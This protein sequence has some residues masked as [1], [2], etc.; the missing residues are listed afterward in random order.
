MVN[1]THILVCENI[2]DEFN[3]GHRGIKVK[4]NTTLAKFNYL[5]TKSLT[6]DSKLQM[7]L[8]NITHILCTSF[9]GLCVYLGPCRLSC[10][11]VCLAS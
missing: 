6:D 1:C 5:L 8:V 7:Q 11:D 9:C 2:L 4:V 3:I 10:L